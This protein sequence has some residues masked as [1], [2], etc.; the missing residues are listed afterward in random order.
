[1]NM[2][3]L[4]DDNGSTR[5]TWTPRLHPLTMAGNRRSAQDRL[6]GERLSSA[7]RPNVILSSELTALPQDNLFQRQK[8]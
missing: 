5:L 6:P 8:E 1:M 3:G 7:D 2:R 4:M